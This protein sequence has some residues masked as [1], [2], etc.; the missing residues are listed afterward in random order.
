MVNRFHFSRE[1]SYSLRGSIKSR[2]WKKKKKEQNVY[3]FE[4]I[5]NKINFR[6]MFTA[7]SLEGELL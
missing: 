5:K 2:F 1:I 7:E 4:N 3:S 6:D